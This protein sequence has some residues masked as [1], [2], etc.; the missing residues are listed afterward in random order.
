MKVEPRVH[1]HVLTDVFLFTGPRI[2][3]CDFN[4]SWETSMKTAVMKFGGTSVGS[5]EAIAQ[6]TKIVVAE[7]QRWDRICVVL[8]AMSGVTDLLITG[9]EGAARGDNKCYREVLNTLKDKHYQVLENLLS[10][11]EQER[12]K[13]AINNDLDAFETFCSSIA[14]LGEVTPRAMDVVSS[15]GEKLIVELSAAILRDQGLDCRGVDSSELIITDQTFQNAVPLMDET[16]RRVK[17]ILLP[18]MVDNILPIVTGYKAANMEGVTTTLGR[19][20]SDYSAAILA[21]CLDADELWIW[22]DVDGVMTADPKIIPDAQVIPR[23]SYQELSELAYFGA[24]VVHPRTIR[25][26]IEKNIPIRVGNTFQPQLQGTMILPEAEQIPSTVKAITVIRDLSL[27]NVAG[28]GML[29]VPGIAARTFAAVASQ[30]ASVLMITQ[31]SS[32]QSIA[33]V[34]ETSRSRGVIEAVEREMALEL[35][36]RD[37]DRIWSLDDV[38]IVTAVGRGL[39]NT[40]GVGAG[41]FTALADGQV[42]VIAAAQGSSESC[43]SLVVAAEDAE[44]AVREIH[45]RVIL[46]P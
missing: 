29:G 9:A 40:P 6:M 28:R 10:P 7:N 21:D 42:N 35:N 22:T 8:S 39:R 18:Q 30:K 14:V 33:F 5:V 25:P 1:D 41:I 15:L 31:A 34:I 36:R 19:G 27:V 12:V 38:V 11:A 4:T 45:D 2:V 23:L 37:I 44:R 16:C 20:G 17:D 26:V 13:P 43:L 3:N 46:H 24:K 32:E